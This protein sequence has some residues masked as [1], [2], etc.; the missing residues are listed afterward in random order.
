MENLNAIGPVLSSGLGILTWAGSKFLREKKVRNTAADVLD[1]G[2]NMDYHFKF[3]FT[4]KLLNKVAPALIGLSTGIGA[5]VAEL[6]GEHSL[7]LGLAGVSLPHLI[8]IPFNK[9]VVK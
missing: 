5:I 8:E 4:T 3:I 9:K 7:A 2:D 1:Y 6:N